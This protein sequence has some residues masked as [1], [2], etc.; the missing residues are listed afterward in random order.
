MINKYIL[1]GIK[2]IQGN[3]EKLIALLKQLKTWINYDFKFIMEL[4]YNSFDAST[5]DIQIKEDACEDSVEMWIN[6]GDVHLLAIH[7]S[8]GTDY[9]F[10]ISEIIDFQSELLAYEMRPHISTPPETIIT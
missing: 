9:I 10:A 3:K 5:Y 4:K 2:K 8:K 1:N 7:F 6:Y